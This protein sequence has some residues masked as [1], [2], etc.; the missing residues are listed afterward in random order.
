MASESGATSTR[1]SPGRSSATPHS[2]ATTR[3]PTDGDA[4]G[5][6]QRRR[7]EQVGAGVVVAQFRLGDVADE[8]HLVFDAEEFDEAL[9][10]VGEVARAPEYERHVVAPELLDG[11][12][13]V[14]DALLVG[15]ATDEKE[16]R[17]LDAEFGLQIPAGGLDRGEP[18]VDDGRVAAVLV[19]DPPG[20]E[21]ADGDEAVRALD[22]PALGL[23]LALW[24]VEVAVRG[25]RVKRRDP[26]DVV[27]RGRPRAGVVAEPVVGVDDVRVGRAGG[28]L[29]R[30]PA[31]PGTDVAASGLHPVD[32]VAVLRCVLRGQDQFDLDVV[33]RVE[34]LEQLADRRVEPAGHV[35]REPPP[36]H[37]HPRRHF[38]SV[39]V[40]F[41]Y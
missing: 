10:L 30:E 33:V 39:P 36:E 32:P 23:D 26:L 6:G 25:Q 17:P 22:Q 11:V 40:P 34:L 8:L 28:E 4:E 27:V 35:R 2:L 13:Q 15:M 31:D 1:Q 41:T 18:V 9:Q 16:H 3:V 37:Q 7:D 24:R 19:V 21:V 20:G 29:P 14:G 38:H 12:D 5:L